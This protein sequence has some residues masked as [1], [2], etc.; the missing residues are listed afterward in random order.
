MTSDRQA[1]AVDPVEPFSKVIRA[2]GL[3]FVKSQIGGDSET[4]EYPD[5]IGVQ[6]RN[7]LEHLEHALEMAGSR[8][9]NAMK[10]NVYLSHIDRDFE[11]MD[12]SFVKFFEERGVTERPARTA[13]GAALSWPQLLVQM[14]L[15]AVAGD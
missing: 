13:I 8:L 10:L 7:T 14:D 5:D 4:G 6:T 3:V 12:A 2:A 11:A 1:F 9:A 15:V